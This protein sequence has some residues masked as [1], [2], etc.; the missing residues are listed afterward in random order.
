MIIIILIL[1]NYKILV[2]KVLNKS[3]IVSETRKEILINIKKILAVIDKA[4]NIS[5][6][7]LKLKLDEYKKLNIQAHGLINVIWVLMYGKNRIN[8]EINNINAD[9]E[10]DANGYVN[11]YKNIV[12]EKISFANNVSELIDE[13]MG[14]LMKIIQMISQ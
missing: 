7:K 1:V 11:K 3:T 14:A 12:N 4:S 10:K 9:K 13:L 8:D 5:K 2:K 6:N